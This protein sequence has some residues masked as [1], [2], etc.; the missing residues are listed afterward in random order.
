MLPPI[1]AIKKW[2]KKDQ[3][4]CPICEK[5]IEDSVGRGLVKM[6]FNVMVAVQRGYTEDVLK[7]RRKPSE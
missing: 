4:I 6:Q 3:Y 1:K 7:Y 2:L 5:V